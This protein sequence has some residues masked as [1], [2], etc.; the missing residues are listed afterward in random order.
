M[1]PEDV[2]PMSADISI[3]HKFNFVATGSTGARVQ[4][5]PPSSK[6]PQRRVLTA[7]TNDSNDT[8]T[9]NDNRNSNS[10]Y[11]TVGAQVFTI[12]LPDFNFQQ[13]Q[14]VKHFQFRYHPR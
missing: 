12:A 3:G 13:P 1:G 9:K 10:P 8:K 7:L 2:N 6:M 5:N 14:I 4:I 11:R